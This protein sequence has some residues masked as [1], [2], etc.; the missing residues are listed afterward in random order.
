MHTLGTIFKIHTG[1]SKI[2]VDKVE[3]L[4]PQTTVLGV[5]VAEPFRVAHHRQILPV[6]RI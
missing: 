2:A 5:Q 1:I 3:V 6:L 4:P